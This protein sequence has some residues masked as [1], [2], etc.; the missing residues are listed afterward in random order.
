MLNTYKQLCVYLQIH[1]VLMIKPH[2]YYGFYVLFHVETHV[3]VTKIHMFSSSYMWK[4]IG[5]KQLF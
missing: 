3:D 4:H 5:L 1:A 2:H